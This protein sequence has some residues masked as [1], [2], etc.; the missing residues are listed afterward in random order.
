MPDLIQHIH[1]R[2]NAASSKE[3][4]HRKAKSGPERVQR[5]AAG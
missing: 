5:I 4:L 2:S 3:S 1:L